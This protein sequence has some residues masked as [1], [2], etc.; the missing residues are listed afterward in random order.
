MR[1]TWPAR[2]TQVVTCTYDYAGRMIRRGVGTALS[3]QTYTYTV[4]DGQNAYLQVSDQYHLAN[5][6]ASASVSQRYLYGPAVDQI[7]ATDNGGGNVFWGLGDYE[8]TIRDVL[9]A[10]GIEQNH[11]T[12]NSLGNPINAPASGFLFG[13]D[14]MRYDLQTNE[15]LTETERYDPATGQRLSQDPLGFASGTTN[16]TAWAGN[17]AVQNVDPT[18]ETYYSVATAA[19]SDARTG[20]K[21]CTI[22][23]TPGRRWPTF[24]PR[25]R[26]ISNSTSPPIRR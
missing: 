1:P 22:S 11:I 19:I 5:G 24:R 17:N 16:L 20:C 7:L 6:G 13:L 21:R 12:F 4:Y 26:H 14:G 18:G 8:G 23:R 9:N 3:S 25:T 10:S 15:Y 2:S